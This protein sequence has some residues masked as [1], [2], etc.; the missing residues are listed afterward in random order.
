MPC[1]N[2]CC[3]GRSDAPTAVVWRFISDPSPPRPP[4]WPAVCPPPLARVGQQGAGTPPTTV[5]CYGSCGRRRSHLLSGPRGLS[6]AARAI[7][8]RSLVSIPR[9]R[10]PEVIDPMR[11]RPQGGKRDRPRKNFTVTVA[12]ERDKLASFSFISCGDARRLLPPRPGIARNSCNVMGPDPGIPAPL[13][14]I[15]RT[16][17]MWRGMATAGATL[18]GR[19]RLRL[20][21]CCNWSPSA[22]QATGAERWRVEPS[23]H[24]S[25][26]VPPLRLLRRL[27]PA[28]LGPPRLSGRRSPPGLDP[29]PAGRRWSSPL[30]PAP[31]RASASPF[32]PR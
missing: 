27:R 6:R 18:R 1:D 4:I 12:T 9:L 30:A 32:R 29:D 24:R 13:R 3:C 5:R 8:V 31:V 20:S 15:D 7:K 16:S 23:A 22:S 10:R 14:L 26:R 17:S 11:D 28:A 25:P 21:P 19:R 2:R